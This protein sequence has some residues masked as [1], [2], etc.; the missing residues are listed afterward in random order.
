MD[1]TSQTHRLEEP[2]SVTTD[3]C[4]PYHCFK[5]FAA[6][7]VLY[8]HLHLWVCDGCKIRIVTISF[9]IS[10][11]N[12]VHVDPLNYLVQ[13]VVLVDTVI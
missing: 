4:A 12:Y 13:V 9:M 1:C 8:S 2:L 6:P 10:L 11:H 7:S 5:S 3:G